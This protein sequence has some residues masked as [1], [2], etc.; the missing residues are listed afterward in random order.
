MDLD[1]DLFETILD[2]LY[3]GVYIVDRE[4]RIRYWNRAAFEIT[5]FCAGEMVGSL[6]CDDKLRH[7]D[8]A[9]K[10]LCIEDCPLAATMEDGG[11]RQAEVFLRHHDGYRVPILVRAMPIR[12]VRGN[13][14]GAV[15]IFSDNTKQLQMMERVR[16]LKKMAM[17]DPLT[18]M[19]NRRFMEMNV[20]SRI[21]EVQ[22]FDSRHGLL[23][24][25]VDRF[26]SFNDKH[27]HETGDEALKV[28]SKTLVN[29]MRFFD[30]LGRWGGEE[31]LGLIVNVSED[32][33]GAIA[34]RF[35][36]LVRKSALCRE[37]EALRV[38][39]TIGAT[40]ATAED[41][42]ERAVRR[43]D[44]LMY[45]GKSHGGDCVVL[46]EEHSYRVF[47]KEGEVL[48]PT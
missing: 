38:T 32:G 47:G 3:D 5:G 26:K 19:P 39:V 1:P 35:A 30:L 2:N 13:I 40:L 24:I 20:K 33:L 36:S 31:F 9:G 11:I 29:G 28:V 22:R 23:F 18:G 10:N 34:R 7:I 46:G 42:V 43:A 25:D 21:S 12:D 15:E 8:L 41:S 14:T 48:V 4:R 27:G 16:E 17:F 45:L 37:N 6:C 44:R